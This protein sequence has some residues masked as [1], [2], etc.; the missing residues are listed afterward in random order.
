VAKS[1]GGC[2]EE[3]LVANL[4]QQKVEYCKEKV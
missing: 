4:R 2:K 1:F 3:D